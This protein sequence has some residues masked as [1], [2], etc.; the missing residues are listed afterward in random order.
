MPKNQ[1]NKQILRKKKIKTRNKEI[2]ETKN[3]ENKTEK[4]DYPGNILRTEIRSEKEI[5]GIVKEIVG[6]GGDI[7]EVEVK[8]PALEDIYFTL[9]GKE[10]EGGL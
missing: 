8:R 3:K 1:T 6:E 9:T 4:T 7:Y 2:Q 5:P 10:K